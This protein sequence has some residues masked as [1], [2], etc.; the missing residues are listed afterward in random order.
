MPLTYVSTFVYKHN[1]DFEVG[2]HFYF[3]ENKTSQ[4]YSG[5]QAP[6][7]EIPEEASV[8]PR[9]SASPSQATRSRASHSSCEP[10]GAAKNSGVVREGR[11]R[12]RRAQGP[13]RL[14]FCRV[15]G[16]ERQVGAI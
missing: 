12:Q 15:L 8:S 5:S 6:P 10:E 3:S 2:S 16:L 4:T 7:G 9:L 11:T 14:L 13:L 1:E